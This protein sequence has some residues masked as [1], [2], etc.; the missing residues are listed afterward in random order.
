MSL[1]LCVCVCVSV[2]VCLCVCV[3]VCVPDVG[4]S[5]SQTE[6]SLQKELDAERQRYQNLLKEISRVEQKYENLKEE[7]SL[8][9]VRSLSLLCNLASGGGSHHR[10]LQ[11]D[12][13]SRSQKL[14]SY[15]DVY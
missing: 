15:E 4:N 11:A 13:I 1:I 14:F 8:T 10:P 12:V 7:L 9:K 3:C 5:V 6:V 2:C